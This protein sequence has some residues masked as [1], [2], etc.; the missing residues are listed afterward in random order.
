MIYTAIISDF[1]PLVNNFTNF[2]RI[3]FSDALFGLRKYPEYGK[4]D[5]DSF[6][7]SA[8]EKLSGSDQDRSKVLKPA[9]RIAN[10]RE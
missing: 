10:C 8:P 2:F 3:F 7:G 9:L 1:G 4:N 6:P 5:K